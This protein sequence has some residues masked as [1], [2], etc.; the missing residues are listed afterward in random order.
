MPA[1]ADDELTASEVPAARAA[2]ESPAT[3]HARY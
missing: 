1:G 2:D 3:I